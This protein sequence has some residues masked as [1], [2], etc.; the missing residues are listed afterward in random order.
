M[1]GATVWDTESARITVVN[2]ET[3]APNVQTGYP[4]KDNE[5]G[6]IAAG[7]GDTLSKYV[8]LTKLTGVTRSSFNGSVS[9]SVGSTIYPIVENVQCYIQT[10]KKWVDLRTL[11]GF[12]D[13]FEAYYDRPV[14]EGGKI[15]LIVAK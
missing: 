13:S 10:T 3:E 4:F 15:R 5:A 9:L 7:Y 14:S 8:D 12:S 2:G 11:R 1:T 6:G